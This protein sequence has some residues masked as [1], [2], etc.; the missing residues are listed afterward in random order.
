MAE[1]KIPYLQDATPAKL[2]TLIFIIVLIIILVTKFIVLK[3]VW[4]INPSQGILP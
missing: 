4:V 3:E 1:I 2:L